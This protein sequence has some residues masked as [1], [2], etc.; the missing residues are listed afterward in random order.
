[1]NGVITIKLV[2]ALLSCGTIKELSSEEKE[3]AQFIEQNFLPGEYLGQRQSNDPINERIL[4][5]QISFYQAADENPEQFENV[6]MDSLLNL[7]L[8][9]HPS[10]GMNEEEYIQLQES[11]RSRKFVTDST[12][13]FS[14]KSKNGKLVFESE[15][16]PTTYKYT[17]LNLKKA[18][19]RF[20]GQ[21]HANPRKLTI[22]SDSSRYG[23]KI[24]LYEFTY[25]DPSNVTTEDIRKGNNERITFNRIRFGKVD[26]TNELLIEY[27]LRD[28]NP[29]VAIFGSQIKLVRAYE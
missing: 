21:I 10:V 15:L 9:Y 3:A 6:L 11:A 17:K 8:A 5:A 24:I 14:I 28:Y 12:F 27:D 22:S 16:N 18:C 20:S 29:G 26:S 13:Y 4:D 19:V 7:P 23:G 1:M 2:V 25:L